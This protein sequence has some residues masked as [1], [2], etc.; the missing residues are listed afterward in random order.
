MQELKDQIGYP[1][2]KSVGALL[3]YQPLTAPMVRN[4]DGPSVLGLENHF[5]K[6]GKNSTGMLSVV[7]LQAADPAH[8]AALERIG[9]AF[10]KDMD[11][12]AA[13]LGIN[14]GWKYLNYADYCEDPIA[15]YGE[16]SVGFLQRVSKRY[17]PYG[18]FQNL[19]QTGFKIPL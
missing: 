16:K 15:R 13:E 2:D 5:A 18:V 14:W 8:L 19:R 10:Q 9:H 3:Q 12:H 7:L 1:N 6:A 4:G 17:D 11:G